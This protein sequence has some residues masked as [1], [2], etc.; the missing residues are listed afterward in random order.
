MG[1]F[2]DVESYLIRGP[3]NAKEFIPHGGFDSLEVSSTQ[4]NAFMQRFNMYIKQFDY[5]WN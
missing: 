2:R 4:T 3:D 5:D 1:M